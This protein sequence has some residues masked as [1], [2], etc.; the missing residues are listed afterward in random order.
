MSI[1]HDSPER[2]VSFSAPPGLQPENEA[3]FNNS[4]EGIIITDINRV[5]LRVN[6][7]FARITGYSQ[8]EVIG[9]TP[10]FLKSQRHDNAFFQRID[11]SLQTDGKWEGEI[12]NRRK[13]GMIYPQWLTILPIK[14]EDKFD[15]YVG[16]FTDIT[17]YINS[18]TTIRNHAYYDSLTGLPNRMFL[19]DRLTFMLNLARRRK[20]ILGVLLLDLNRF[21]LINDTL[22]YTF[23]DQLLQNVATRLKSCTR[24]VDSVFRLGDDEFAILLED[25][26]H[27]QDAARVAKRILSN[28]SQPYLIA[29]KEL[30][31]TISIGVSLFPGDGEQF[32]L[33]LKNAEA[34]MLRAKELGISNYQHYKPSMNTQAFEQ[35]TLEYNLQKALNE[36]QFIVFYQPLINLK[37]REIIGAEALIRWQH[38]DLGMVPPA[39]FIPL[40]EETGLIIPIGEWVLDTACRQ[41][42]LWQKKFKKPY[43]ISVN[44]SARQFQ[45]K[46]LISMVNRVLHAV[47]FDPGNLK[48][49][50]TESI[51]MKNPE[52]TILILNELKSMGIPIAIDD[53]GTGYSS[54]SYL[55]RFPIDTIKIDRSFV[56]E[57]QT[58]SNDTAIVDAII[59]MAHSLNL[60]V[61]AEGVETLEQAEY[62]ARKECEQVQGFYFSKPV[63][64]DDF[65]QLLKNAPWINNGKDD[66]R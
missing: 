47:S 62:L 24:E 5:I 18:N 14:K 48:L 40:A 1:D 11:T 43:V 25:I 34:A 65:E 61:I 50:I 27:P 22:G 30:F 36:K 13:N 54:L 59:A 7:G 15:R 29:D 44:L 41:M 28:C 20:G 2:A 60:N 35:L 66:S 58:G 39:Q 17:A 33:L 46:D 56:M 10:S 63:F 53:F 49:E 12:W 21:K 9:K 4:S 8:D 26:L 57:M 51:G 64:I 38:P 31:V 42:R 55:K 23:G 19:Y 32:E 6:P 16:I 45:Q 52:Q 3:I 37:N